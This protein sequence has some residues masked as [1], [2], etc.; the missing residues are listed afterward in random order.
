LGA[1]EVT[2]LWHDPHALPNMVI[3]FF[4]VSKAPAVS[5]GHF[6]QATL[7]KEFKKKGVRKKFSLRTDG[8]GC[9]CRFRWRVTN[10]TTLS[11]F[12]SYTITENKWSLGEI[13]IAGR[14]IFKK[15]KY[16]S[17]RQ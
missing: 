6:S 14:D 1:N 9:V 11:H 15:L 7:K 13:K 8:G 10:T 3:R 12:A 5:T 17:P 16:L 4:A 2:G